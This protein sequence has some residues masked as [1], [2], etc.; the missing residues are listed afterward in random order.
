MEPRS[1]IYLL[2]FGDPEARVACSLRMVI[3]ILKF[4]VVYNIFSTPHIYIVK[5]LIHF[6]DHLKKLNPIS[7]YKVKINLKMST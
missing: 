1:E 5:L 3:N 6:S 4:H 7:D 2:C